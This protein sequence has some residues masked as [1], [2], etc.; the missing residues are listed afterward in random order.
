MSKSFPILE[1]L[2]LSGNKLNYNEIQQGSKFL[3]LKRIILVNMGLD[4]QGFSNIFELFEN[5]Q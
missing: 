3:N 4:W 2:S 1:V 5:C